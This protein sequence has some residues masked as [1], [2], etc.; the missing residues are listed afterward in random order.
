[1]RVV[2]SA[3]DTVIVCFAES[4]NDFR[5]HHPQLHQAMVQAWLATYPTEF[6]DRGEDVRL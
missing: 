4:P 1:M 5:R 6:E 3:V 2:A